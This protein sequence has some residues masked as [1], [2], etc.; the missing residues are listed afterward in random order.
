MKIK[1]IK[2]Y[3][4]AAVWRNFVIVEV[5]TDEGIKGYGEG[6]LGDFEKTIEAAVNDLKPFLINRDIEIN[7]ITNFFLRNFF[8]RNGPILSTAQSAIEQALWDAVGKTVRQPVYRLLG[9]KAVNRVKVYANGFISGGAKPEEFA[10]AAVK[11]VEKG[12][13]ALKFDPFGGAGP[14]ITRADLDM[15][16]QRIGAIRDAVGSDIDLMIEAHGRFNTRTAIK[17]AKEIERYDPFWLEEPVPEEDIVSMSEVRKASGVPIAAGERIISRNRFWELLSQR[18]VDIIQPDVC[19]MGG[20]MP[21]VEV[22]AMANVNY[23]TVAPHNPNGPIATA[24]SL[25]AL[26]TM[27]NALIL[28]FWLD[29]ETVRHDLIK[30]YFDVRDGYIYPRDKPGLGIEINEEA[31]TK[32]P[33]KKMHLEY[34][35]NEYKY[36]GDIK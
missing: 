4:A 13:K 34:F 14:N 17:I 21:L 11:T 9:G 22:G 28:E 36:H 2:T 35:S 24:A 18:A 5:T 15:A 19:H 12:Y 26:V 31:L 10:S 30:E 16:K 23:V 20:I 8:W 29:A 33:Y 1:E 27:P 6:T 32:Y 7:E 25:N 3:F